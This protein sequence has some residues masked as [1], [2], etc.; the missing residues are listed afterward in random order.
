MKLTV[1]VVSFLFTISSLYA[2]NDVN[3]FVEPRAADMRAAKII[4][5]YSTLP[6]GEVSFG[7]HNRQY[8]YDH[9]EL[10]STWYDYQHNA[11]QG[12]Q[13]VVGDDGV[14][15]FAW[16]KAFAAGANVRH[17]VYTCYDDPIPGNSVDNSQRSGYCTIDVL[18]SDAVYANAAVVGFH[19][20]P[21]T[22]FIT[23]LSPDYGPCWQAFHP[24]NHPIVEEWWDDDQPMW[25]HIAV[26]VA[27]I[28]D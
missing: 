24:L 11:S 20:Q 14:V 8:E 13:I 17:V 2:I 4:T 23:A 18:G 26:D 5:P 12:K 6:V 15:H 21:N 19:Q 16:M 27:N 28:A 22:D 7:R 3:L 10:G 25:P 1:V 9:W